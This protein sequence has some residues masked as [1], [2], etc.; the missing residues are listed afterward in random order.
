MRVSRRGALIG[1]AAG[2]ASVGLG[3][4]AAPKFRRSAPAGSEPAPRPFVID[5]HVHPSPG[6]VP[7]LLALM[8]RWGFDRV[9]DLSGGHPLRGLPEHLSAAERAGGRIIV[10]TGLAYEQA[11]RPGYGERMAEF[12]RAGHRM[13]A[14]GLKITKML[15]LHLR[16]PDG[17]LLPVDDPE[18]DAVFQAAG[19]LSMP[20][21]IHSGDPRA[22]WLPVDARNERLDELTAHPGWALNGKPVPSF[23]E[24]LDQLERRIARHPKT[25][26]VSVHFG[27]DAEEPERVAR[28]LRQYPNMYIDTAARVPE[29]GR[30]PP[31]RMHA[32]FVEFQ[33]R[34][35]Y[36]SDLGI[37]AEG[38]LIL[39]SDGSTPAGDAEERRFFQATRRYFETGD[40]DFEHPTPIQGNWKISGIHLPHEILSKVYADNA[41][42]LIG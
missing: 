10:F 6:A 38:P 8:Q 28:M 25:R 15:G 3:L 21:A 23:K 36:G 24:I 30:H 22:F 17:E 12:V 7:R 13:G 41:R 33:D 2:S 16:G 29:M 34:I 5:A 37:G 39:G 1:V 42:S 27:N 4:C 11:A 18:L 31:E 32:F 35:L 26:F 40:R 20:V 19:E 14:R 9:V